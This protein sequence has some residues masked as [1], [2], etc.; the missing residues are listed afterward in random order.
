MQKLYD[1]LYIGIPSGITVDSCS[2]GD[3]W[4]AVR[5]NGNIG[6]ARTLERPADA[7]DFAAR[8][9]GRYLRDTGNHMQWHTPAEA[10]V[11]VAA[12]NAWYNTAERVKGLDGIGTRRALPG[13]IAYVGD[14]P[15]GSCAGSDVFPMPGGPGFDAGPYE[16]L[17]AYDNVVIASEAL[18]TRALPGLLDIVGEDGNVV[19]EG[20]SLPA[21]ALFFAFDMPIRELRGFYPRFAGTVD[22]CARRNIADPAPGMLPFCISSYTS[23]AHLK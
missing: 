6:I 12:L 7:A 22:A 9:A 21:S 1:D 11:G 15:E 17:A 2:I 20:Y 13:K 14:F 10:S 16:A 19:L 23:P 4:T 3:I 5:A 8:C 18:I